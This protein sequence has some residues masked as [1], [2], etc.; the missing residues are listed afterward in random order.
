MDHKVVVGLFQ[1]TGEHFC[2]GIGT[3]PS[4][5]SRYDSRSAFVGHTITTHRKVDNIADSDINDTEETLVL[6]LKFLLVK[7][8]DRK[9]AVLIDSPASAKPTVNTFALFHRRDR[10]HVQV[11]WFI[12]VGI[13]SFLDHRGGM[14]LLSSDGGHGERI[15]K[16]CRKW[17]VS[18]PPNT[19]QLIPR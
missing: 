14:C 11:E 8:L 12:P 3:R 18:T 1:I 10:I 13:Q 2:C 19:K 15:R 16:A 6:L 7:D 9:Y 4:G 17:S 5:Q